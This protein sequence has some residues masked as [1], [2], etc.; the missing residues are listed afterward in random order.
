MKGVTI[1]I[2][3]TEASGLVSADCLR[4]MGWFRP[5]VAQGAFGQ[6][7]VDLAS[8]LVSADCS[9]VVGWF[10]RLRRK[11]LEHRKDRVSDWGRWLVHYW[12]IHRQ[13]VLLCC[14]AAL[15]SIG[16]VH[17]VLLGCE[18]WHGAQLRM[19]RHSDELI[20]I[21]GSSVHAV[22]RGQ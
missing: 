3:G 21:S 14:C 15:L 5:L 1:R 19:G 16:P 17:V 12:T 18:P 22:R 4:V 20:R 11:V 13:S 6:D 7:L 8:G 9:R 2:G 10:D